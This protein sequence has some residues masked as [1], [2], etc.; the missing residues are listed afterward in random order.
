MDRCPSNAPARCGLENMPLTTIK[1]PGV[2]WTSDDSVRKIK[3]RPASCMPLIPQFQKADA[4]EVV[5]VVAAA[6][7]VFGIVVW[8]WLWQQKAKK[9]KLK[10]LE[11]SWPYLVGK[12]ES[13]GKK[14]RIQSP[15]T[16]M[17]G[18]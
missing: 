13:S 16:G 6:A 5:A 18:K 2:C 14:G 17:G 15:E 1:H 3:N 10:C 8:S 4:C 9:K 7:V 12:T 11:R